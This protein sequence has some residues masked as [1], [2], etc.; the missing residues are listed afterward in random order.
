MVLIK[1]DCIVLIN[2]RHILGNEMTDNV[3][4]Q[5]NP[6]NAWNPAK[7]IIKELNMRILA[8]RITGL[9]KFNFM[10]AEISALE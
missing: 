8:T 5:Y 3:A 6:K 1:T 7:T 2:Q 10:C 9:N 4:D